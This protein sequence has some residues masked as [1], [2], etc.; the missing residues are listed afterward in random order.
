M[1]QRP[2]TGASTQP[3]HE[4]R[5]RIPRGMAQQ[6]SRNGVPRQAGQK[7][8]TPPPRVDR[9]RDAEFDFGFIPP[10]GHRLMGGVPGFPVG[11]GIRCSHGMGMEDGGSERIH[12][13]KRPVRREQTPPDCVIPPRYEG[14]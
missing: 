8:I 2:Q 12:G 1:P 14:F 11:E 13:P 9:P 7:L 5:L 10:H 4:K 6:A 3:Q